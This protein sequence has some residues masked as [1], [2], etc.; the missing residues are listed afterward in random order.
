[1]GKL[2]WVR[3]DTA[4]K[5]DTR[6]KLVTTALERNFTRIIIRNDDKS[7]FEKLGKLDLILIENGKF[8]INGKYGEYITI[9]N[10]QDQER[11]MTLVGKIDYLLISAKDWKVIPV[12]NLIAA[13]QNSKSKLL[14]EVK[15]T[16]EAK[17]F[18]QTLEVGV[19]GVVLNSTDPKKIIG[20]RKLINELEIKKLKLVSGKVIGIKS[21]GT[22]DRVCI[23][24][25]SILGIGEGMLIGSQ[26]N[27]LILV[28]SESIESEYVDSRPFRVNAGSVHSYI[29]APNDKTRYL[30]E[31]RAG[32]EVL[33]V[34]HSGVTRPVI[35]G[36][37]KIEKR[38]LIL[39][40]VGYKNE[41][42]NIILQNAETIRLISNGKPVSIVDLKKGDS[43]QLWVEQSGRHFGMK[44]SESIQEK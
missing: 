19:D 35:I 26:A 25:C 22:G 11:A 43:I 13:V 39:L 1:M 7:T 8:K 14:V 10:K 12:E 27:G 23:D 28:H 41:K 6:K 33:A 18:L 9:K 15:S 4:E 34:D 37:V 3:A 36:R 31:L 5:Q 21:M 24:T 29:L 42:F 38:P 20:L 2:V 30:S 32:D 16:K 44:V 17:L 40:E